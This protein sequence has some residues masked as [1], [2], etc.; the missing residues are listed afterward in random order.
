[1]GRCLED[2]WTP[3][4]RAKG[5]AKCGKRMGQAAFTISFFLWKLR[6]WLPVILKR[7]KLPS[8]KEMGRHG[9]WYPFTGFL[10]GDNQN[11]IRSS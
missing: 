2:V 7:S 8:S 5:G 6:R 4:V 11:S 1:M 10:T 9:R 3:I